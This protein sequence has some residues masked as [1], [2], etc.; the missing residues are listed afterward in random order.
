MRKKPTRRTFLTAAGALLAGA[1]HGLS[2][3]LGAPAAPG[4]K[5]AEFED[6]FQRLRPPAEAWQSLPWHTSIL[7]ARGLAARERKP[8]YMLVRSGHPLGC[9]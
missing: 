2:P 7:Q 9:V 3:V 8:I 5:D 6:L 1:G 4:L